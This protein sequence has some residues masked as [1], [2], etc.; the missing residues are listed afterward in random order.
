MDDETRRLLDVLHR[1]RHAAQLVA[2]LVA[3]GFDRDEALNL[4]QFPE[5][6]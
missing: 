5:E 6:E 1:E 3:E 2:R 4:V